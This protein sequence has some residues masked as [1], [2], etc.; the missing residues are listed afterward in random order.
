MKSYVADAAVVNANGIKTLLANGL[1]TFP[2]NGNQV[3][4]NSPKG[5][6]KSLLDCTI[7]CN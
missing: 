4:S 1:S 2:I 5:L 7:L 6:A 3:F